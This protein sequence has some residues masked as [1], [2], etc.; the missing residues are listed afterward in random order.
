MKLD[1]ILDMGLGAILPIYERG[2][3]TKVI[4]RDGSKFID[5]RTLKTVLKN[6]AR[7]YSVDLRATRK[8]YGKFVNKRHSIPLPLAADLILIPVKVREKP[9]GKNDGTL[10]Y[11]NFFEIVQVEDKVNSSSS[12]ILKSGDNI[13]TLLGHATILEYVKNARL[14]EKLYLSRHFHGTDNSIVI[15]ESDFEREYCIE[16]CKDNPVK[17]C[18]WERPCKYDETFLR[19]YLMEL[20]MEIIR[21]QENQAKT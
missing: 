9:L 21:Q 20:L 18:P 4:S 14:V 6:I 7:F 10:G 12:I 3:V 19:G 11:V 16:M 1:G 13:I 17:T 2:N 5:K 15:K 8:Q